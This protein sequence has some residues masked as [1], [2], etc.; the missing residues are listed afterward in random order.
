MNN[1]HKAPDEHDTREIFVW[2]GKDPHTDLLRLTDAVAAKTKAELFRVEGNL[3]RLRDGHFI[4]VDKRVM[5]AIIARHL[6]TFRFV[7]RGNDHEPQWEIEFHSFGF[8]PDT[9]LS[10]GP[11]EQTLMNLM[12]A[13]IPKVASGPTRPNNFS[14]HEMR[15]ILLRLKQGDT[16]KLI[17]H[18]FGC[19]IDTIREIDRAA[20][21]T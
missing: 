5:I 18:R 17:A 10:F 3:C 2:F 1:S 15:E 11:N 12:S 14:N 13:L 7:N 8:L 19:E 21:G 9:N 4:T 16:E 6:K 20:R